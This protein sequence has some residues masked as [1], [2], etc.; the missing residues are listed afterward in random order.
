MASLVKV[1]AALTAAST[2]NATLFTSLIDSCGLAPYS[3]KGKDA[4]K[5]KLGLDGPD[6]VW[7][8]VMARNQAPVG[9][10]K[11]LTAKDLQ[12]IVLRDLPS[13]REYFGDR[14]EYFTAFDPA[15]D[16][17]ETSE[18]DAGMQVINNLAA[19]S[20]GASGVIVSFPSESLEEMC[21][22]KLIHPENLLRSVMTTC[23]VLQGDTLLS[24]QHNN[25]GTT[26][27]TL[28][29]GSVAWIVW[30][31]S[32]HN[33]NTLQTAYEQYAQDFDEAKMEVAKDLH[34]GQIFVQTAGDALRIPPFCLMMSLAL[35]TSV[36]TTNSHFIVENF[37][38]M[39]SKLP[40]LY[41][42]YK[43]ET[44][45][46]RH[47]SEFNCSML[48][49]LDLM[50][51]DDGTEENRNMLKLPRTKDGLLDS[52]FSIWDST[53]DDLA[54][55]MGPA[56]SV[57]MVKIW[58]E[59]LISIPGRECRMCNKSVRSKKLVKKHFIDAHWVKLKKRH[60]WGRAV[61][62]NKD[63]GESAQQAEGAIVVDDD[64]DDDEE[65]E[66]DE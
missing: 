31:P 5:R 12:E 2:E 4:A 36:L 56:D 30:P 23:T 13:A 19:A 15:Q 46:E 28:L 57:T 22:E 14:L 9:L 64:D 21:R 39:L 40:L 6:A 65:V 8:P 41:A 48:R 16:S 34:G 3:W 58:E 61:V 37:I 59:F 29:Y 7:Y 42:W 47:Q 17:N 38:D 53:K 54:A 20:D 10:P 45:G 1:R 18:E 24:L 32:D 11:T 43:T 60:D 35:K 62:P 55:I 27:A 26:V 25:E 66:A 49:Y 51:N 50:L 44:D 33:M 52:L 63:V